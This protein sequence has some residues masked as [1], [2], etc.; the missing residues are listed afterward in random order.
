MERGEKAKPSTRRQ[1]KTAKGASHMQTF[2]RERRAAKRLARLVGS[3]RRLVTITVPLLAALTFV[4]IATGAGGALDTSF[5]NGG[6]V[7]T[8][9]SGTDATDV[10]LDV[11]IQR[12]GKFVVAGYTGGGGGGFALA[13]YATDGSL[14]TS[15][16]SGG[17]VVTAFEGTG[18]AVALQQDGK[19]VVA[20]EMLENGGAGPEAFALA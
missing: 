5:G 2:D 10:A 4:A 6:K 15:F 17:K 1:K 20:G 8:D 18:W 7:L 13:R 9:I 19:I 12:D 14:D 16:G 3:P 11:A